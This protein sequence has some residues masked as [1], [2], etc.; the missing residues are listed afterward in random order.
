MMF[1]GFVNAFLQ[2]LAII[3]IIVV[4]GFVIF[5]LGDIVLSILDPNYVRFGHKR[6]NA[7]KSETKEK[8]EVKQLQAPNEEV[9]ELEYKDEPVA[10]NFKAEQPKQEE[11]IAVPAPVEEPVQEEIQEPVEEVEAP[12]EEPVEEPI[13]EV[14]E[15]PVEETEQTEE[16]VVEE[17]QEEVDELRAEEERYRQNMLREIEE[18]RQ[19]QLDGNDSEIENLFFGDDDINV[20]N[21]EEPLVGQ[22]EMQ[23]E[24]P[25]TVPTETGVIE[26]GEQEGQQEVA[27]EEDGKLAELKA[28]FEQE[29]AEL[30]AKNSEL[31]KELEGKETATG[32]SLSLE[33]H[34]ARLETLKERL[35]NN[36]KELRKVK[37]EYIP[38]RKVS[39]T[40]ESDERKLRR[41]E[42]I[43][44][45]E[46]VVL[47]GV[48]NIADIDEEKAKKLSEELDLLEG[49][50]LSVQHCKEVMDNNKERFPILE[51][52]Y[53][54]L[55]NNNE[56]LKEDIKNTEE[57]IAKLKKDAE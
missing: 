37:K 12:I 51:N 52:T 22:E 42:A 1:L 40:L 57:A 2:V 23:L 56:T 27:Q 29:I 15:T 11:V 5:F 6:K 21:D 54:I 10:T 17:K 25:E 31:S 16:P 4:G 28:K 8:E 7:E 47:Y 48:N 34:E 41:K 20:F 13:E 45:K 46:K 39:K 32:A 19:H 55:M 9:K 14:V 38:L 50:K 36:D 26:L 44:A 49:L 43:V 33:E 18:R 53:N 35:A 30:Q 3:G 24:N